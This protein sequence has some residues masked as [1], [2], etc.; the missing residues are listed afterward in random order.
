MATLEDVRRIALALPGVTEGSSYGGFG[1]G[2]EFKGKIRGFVWSWK[3]R[4]DPKKARVENLAVMAIRVPSL[5]IKDMLLAS[6]EGA[7][8]IFTEPHYNGYP[9]VLVRLALIQ[10]DEL[11]ELLVEAHACMSASKPKKR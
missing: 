8:K 11:E 6:D 1:F 4:I 10:P 5:E 3:E 2:V 7:G 9:A